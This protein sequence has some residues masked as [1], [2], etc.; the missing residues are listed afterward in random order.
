MREAVNPLCLASW[1]I[2]VDGNRCEHLT[3][4]NHHPANAVAVWWKDAPRSVTVPE[5]VD[6][7]CACRV[8]RFHADESPATLTRSTELRDA[9]ARSTR[10][11]KP[12]IDEAAQ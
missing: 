7:K 9:N 10:W 12:F 11:R 5:E 1:P 4:T 6:G 3:L 8:V 2:F